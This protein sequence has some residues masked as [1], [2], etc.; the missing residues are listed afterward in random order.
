M[1]C[2][3]ELREA[4]RESIDALLHACVVCACMVHRRWEPWACAP[5]RASA[6]DLNSAC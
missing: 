6:W 2:A 5:S 4:L 1:R 3:Q